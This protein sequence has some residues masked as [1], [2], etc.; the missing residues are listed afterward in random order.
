MLR[1][2]ITSVLTVVPATLSFCPAP[3]TS[4]Q[5]HLAARAE[6]GRAA[7]DD[8][9]DDRAAAAQALLALPG[10]DEE[11]VLHRA[12]LAAGVAVV[13]DRGATGVDPGLQRRDDPVAQRLQVLGLHRAGGRERV[14]LGPEERLVGV[15]VAD[16][17]NAGLVE[18]EGLQRRLP[19][20]RHLPQ[21]LRGELGRERLDAELR[22]ALLQPRVLDQEGLA[23]AAWI[24]EPELA[25]V[26]EH[27]PRPQV[28]LLGRAL[29]LIEAPPLG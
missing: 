12:L 3:R 9:A 18:E 29:V 10:V 20:R 26:V 15:D 14:Q 16:P 13:V 5:F 2:T 1:S 24:G 17:G 21:R 8:D 23:E 6:V 11:L 28:P 19:P 27:E 4:S 22:E 25:A 7:A